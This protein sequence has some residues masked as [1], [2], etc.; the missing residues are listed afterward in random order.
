MNVKNAMPIVAITNGR[1]RRSTRKLSRTGIQGFHSMRRFGSAA[2][3]RGIISAPIAPIIA[4]ASKLSPSTHSWPN[5]SA[6]VCW[7]YVEWHLI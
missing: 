2:G 5:S 4:S 6:P 3:R 1:L 7:S